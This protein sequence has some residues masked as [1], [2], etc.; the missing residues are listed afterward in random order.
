MGVVMYII[1]APYNTLEWSCPDDTSKTC[2]PRV[3]L[4]DAGINQGAAIAALVIQCIVI[5]LNVLGFVGL[6]NCISWML[7]I[8]AI[9]GFVNLVWCL[10]YW[11]LA[12][13]YWYIFW[14]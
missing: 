13:Q 7:M 11:I 14:L 12:V 3:I 6:W 1:E 8:I 4:E 2:D 5:I 10:V 9:V